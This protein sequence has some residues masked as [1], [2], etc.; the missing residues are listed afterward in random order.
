MTLA[1]LEVDVV[2]LAC[3]IS[4]GV[5]AALAPS[6]FG[7]GAAAGVGFVASAVALAGVALWL[8]VRPASGLAL[9]G[10]AF[11][12][13]GLLASYALAV[14][15]GLPLLHSEPEPVESLALATKV[16]EALGLAA[17]SRLLFRPAGAFAP[18]PKGTT[19]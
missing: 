2:I 10:A 17:A 8:T 6:H 15:D 11:V 3:A 19:S 5:H 1:E 9:A 16:I 14:T 12:F 13:A 18:R 7:D 4:A